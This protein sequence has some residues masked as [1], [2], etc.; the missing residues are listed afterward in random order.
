L[1]ALRADVALSLQRTLAILLLLLLFKA[2]H[3]SKCQFLQKFLF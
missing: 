1:H 2:K 3:G